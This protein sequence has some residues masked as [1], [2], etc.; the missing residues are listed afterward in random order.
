M[1]WIHDVDGDLVNLEKCVNLWV[2][3]PEDKPNEYG[4]LVVHPNSLTAIAVGTKEE[5]E[6]RREELAA[7]LLAR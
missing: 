7:V 2:E 4:L 3:Q 5:M 1:Y 6:A